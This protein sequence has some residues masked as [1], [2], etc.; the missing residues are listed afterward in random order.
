MISEQGSDDA[1]YVGGP[2]DGATFT[3]D[4]VAVVEVP[5]RGLAHRYI[6]TTKHREGPTDAADP[7]VYNYDG[8]VDPSGATPGV[9]TERTTG[10]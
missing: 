4:D 6:R 3:S 10:E 1:V 7:V 2:N 5:L 8:V 9:E